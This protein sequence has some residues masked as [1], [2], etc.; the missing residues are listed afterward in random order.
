MFERVV[1]QQLEG[2]NA[3]LAQLKTEAERL[4]MEIAELIGS[5]GIGIE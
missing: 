3:E 5:E 1:E 2:V 4:K